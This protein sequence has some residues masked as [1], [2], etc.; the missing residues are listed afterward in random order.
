MKKVYFSYELAFQVRYQEY[1]K[2]FTLAA[3]LIYLDNLLCI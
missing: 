3:K 1:K 2:T